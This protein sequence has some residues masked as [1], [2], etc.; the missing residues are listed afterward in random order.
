MTKV[1]GIPF[2]DWRTL[3]MTILGHYGKLKPKFVLLYDR[4]L[5]HRNAITGRYNPGQKH[6]GYS[7]GVTERWVSRLAGELETVGLL[8]KRTSP[9]NGKSHQYDLN[10]FMFDKDAYRQAERSCI[11]VRKKSSDKPKK[12]PILRNAK[13]TRQRVLKQKEVMAKIER[14]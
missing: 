9:W 12:K 14:A 4:L 6:L 2:E 13:N 8:S 3:Q 5:D 7:I 1:I 11:E 10:R